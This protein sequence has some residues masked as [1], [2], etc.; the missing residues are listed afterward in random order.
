MYP[1][2]LTMLLDCFTCRKFGEDKFLVGN[3]SIKCDEYENYFNYIILPLL[4]IWAFVIPL[5]LIFALLNVA[6]QKSRDILNIKNNARNNT[7][8]EIS[9]LYLIQN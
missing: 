7:I 5:C 3:T 2:M 1:E 4:V 6:S 8:S 9:N